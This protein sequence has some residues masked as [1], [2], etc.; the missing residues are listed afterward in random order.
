MSRLISSLGLL[1]LYWR[2]LACVHMSIY[3]LF[4]ACPVFLWLL[5]ADR[6]LLRGLLTVP[7]FSPRFGVVC[8]GLSPGSSVRLVC[9]CTC[10]YVYMLRGCLARL[11]FVVVRCLTGYVERKH[12]RFLLSCP[13]PPLRSHRY[14]NAHR[15][16]NA[17]LLLLLSPFL[18]MMSLHGGNGGAFPLL[19]SPK[20]P[21]YTHTTNKQTNNSSPILFSFSGRR[22]PGIGGRACH[23]A[24]VKSCKAACEQQQCWRWWLWPPPPT[25][26]HSLSGQQ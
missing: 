26:R 19:L 10:V 22:H 14:Y 25:P 20:T 7:L 4:V 5:D 8:H 23:L 2:A 6:F 13:H 16:Y 9:L 17:W 18:L 24:P 11:S 21:L 1:C 15:H 12:F 3:M